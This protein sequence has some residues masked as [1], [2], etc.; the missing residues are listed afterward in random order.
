MTVLLALNHLNPLMLTVA[1]NSL[2]ILM[3]SFLW[4]QSLEICKGLMLIRILPT[5]LLQIFFNIIFISKTIDKSIFDPD[6][7]IL[8]YSY[9]YRGLLSRQSV[10]YRKVNLCLGRTHVNNS[11]PRDWQRLK[12][13]APLSVRGVI[14]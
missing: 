11:P 7:N 4:K 12:Y 1:K 8:K 6:D 14:K 10:A 5:T 13:F 2:T 9:K 3:K